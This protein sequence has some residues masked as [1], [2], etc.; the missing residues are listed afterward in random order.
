M[1]YAQRKRLAV[2]HVRELRDQGRDAR[3][4]DHEE[5]LERALDDKEETARRVEAGGISELACESPGKRR[6]LAN[7][8]EWFR[9]HRPDRSDEEEWAASCFGNDSDDGGRDVDRDDEDNFL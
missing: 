9:E 3:E 4:F 5:R 7:A 8:R 6:A 2:E 1:T